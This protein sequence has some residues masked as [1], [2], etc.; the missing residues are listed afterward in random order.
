LWQMI[1]APIAVVVG[2]V[3]GAKIGLKLPD[4]VILKVFFGLLLIIFCR[5]ATDVFGR[6]V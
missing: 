4:A 2:A 3:V 6:Y 5:Y 1:S